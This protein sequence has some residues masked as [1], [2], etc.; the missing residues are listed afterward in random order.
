M[1]GRTRTTKKLAQRID[2]N[3]FKNRFPFTRW[4]LNLSI[5]LTGIGVL[6][7]AWHAV[8]KNP[9]PY[10]SG[11][12][13]VRHAIFSDN[14]AACHVRNGT[15][16]PSVTDQACS[17]CHNGPAHQ[18]QQAFVPECTSCHVEHQGAVVLTRTN[19]K[20]CTQCH[21]DLKTKDGKLNVAAHI[22]SFNSGHPEFTT[23]REGQVD[24]GTVKFNH[25]LHLKK[26]LQS[27]KGNVDLV[28]DNCHR[29][30]GQARP[31]P[32][33]T[34]VE[35]QQASLI[36]G[37]TP[38]S[39]RSSRSY[40]EPVNY[41]EHCSS[42]HSLQFDK[43]INEAVPHPAKSDEV[44]AF[45]DKKLRDY[46]GKN[47]AVIPLIDENDGRIPPRMPP[48]PARNA[49]E[50]VQRRMANAKQLL[51]GKSCKEC[52][53]MKFATPQSN[54]AVDKAN[55]TAR[56]LKNGDFDHQAHQMVQCA[57]CHPK[58]PTSK[59]TSD[60]LLPD[61]KTCQTCHH[62]GDQRAAQSS[63]SECHSYHDWKQE[64][65]LEPKFTVKD[66]IAGLQ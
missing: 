4:R 38:H 5:L 30:S 52:H 43:R 1:A 21:A 57:E 14:C 33:G 6:W 65:H 9:H 48:M 13:S 23:A 34:A 36:P 53:E 37:L 28:C 24:P 54:P 16:A 49:E 27:P 12:I 2:R 41:D 56:W 45:M 61:V 32:F 66:L 59:L 63:C 25:L 51:W 7:L 64:Q 58:A 10:T 19:D 29:P 60:I 47:P 15:F 62:S 31:W 22:D 50:W 17:T 55:I 18:A 35:I 20:A 3:Y 11:P 26:G 42:C 40:M 46:I 44:V 8:A 39:R